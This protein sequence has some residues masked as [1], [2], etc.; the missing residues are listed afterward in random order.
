[1]PGRRRLDRTRQTVTT[2]RHRPPQPDRHYR[3][4][5]GDSRR[6]AHFASYTY[7]GPIVVEALGGDAPIA[8]Y[9]LLFGASGLA[10]VVLVGRFNDR[11][12]QRSTEVTVGI[13][14]LSALGVM[15]TL[16]H[17][18]RVVEYGLLAVTVVAWGAAT[19]AVAPVFQ[20]A[21]IRVAGAER[22]RASAFYVTCFQIGIASGAAIGAVLLGVSI[23]WLPV[24]TLLCAVATLVGVVCS[25]AA[26]G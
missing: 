9:L 2:G 17:A 16:A 19:A 26:F 22:E 20:S 15:I 5:A 18:P 3:R 11:W 12:P 24:V 10:G 25:K 8:F 23:M 4:E 6:S 14:A 21:I 1:M 7:F 13:L